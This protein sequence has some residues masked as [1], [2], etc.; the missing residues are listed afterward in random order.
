MTRTR[1]LTSLGLAA[2]ALLAVPL[3]SDGGANE[4]F[5]TSQS[6]DATIHSVTGDE[7]FFKL[8]IG[9]ANVMM[10]VDNS[11]SMFNLVQCT[12]DSNGRG[13]W[14]DRSGGS[15]C[16]YPTAAELPTPALGV[17]NYTC[18]VG[19]TLDW[20]NLK[21]GAGAPLTKAAA[22]TLVDPG[23]GPAANSIGLLDA[24]TWGTGCTGNACL[25]NK[26]SY[27]Q[28]NS[29]TDTSATA[30]ADY[31]PR[32]TSGN[33]LR[34][35]TAA[36]TYVTVAAPA[37][38]GTCLADKGFCFT[39]TRRCSRWDAGRSN[40]N[41]T[42]NT[43]GLIFAGWW[44]N[45]NPP[46]FMTA[47][48]VLKD[49]VWIDPTK[50]SN[51]DQA[52]FGLS[53]INSSGSR[54]VVPVGPGKADSFPVNLTAMVKARQV[55]LDA[56][57]RVWPAGVSFS[58]ASGG[59][60]LAPAL[61]NVGQY[62]NK[63]VYPVKLGVADS[64]TYRETATG[65][66]GPTR[67]TWASG[68]CAFCWACQTSAVLVVTDGSPN[69]EN[70]TPN[71]MR[72]YG[73]ASYVTNCGAASSYPRCVSPSMGSPTYLPRVAG[74]LQDTDLRTDFSVSDPQKLTTSTIGFGIQSNFGATSNQWNIL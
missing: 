19:G 52:R 49:V 61:A 66:M 12:D 9:P 40:C 8:P 34:H 74:W 70:T 16:V 38:C 57:N 25:F 39:L 15:K 18:T 58:L 6:Y 20:M 41:S 35:Y 26:D 42:T 28:N 69:T 54:I 46:K 14:N 71:G 67:V 10:L 1:S 31:D 5:T 73:E 60:P 11:G 21:D 59:T 23:H 3:R 2:L 48:K 4:C 37:G 64:A 30:L 63:G 43:Y 68:N 72:T 29:W 36:S 24:P 45:A 50:P 47:R 53:I 62:F 56:L 17:T 51:L 65:L 22:P 32:D 44:L 33:K 7:S 55:I 27:Y 13:V